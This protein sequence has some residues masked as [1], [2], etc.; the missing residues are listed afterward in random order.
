MHEAVTVTIHDGDCVHP[1]CLRLC[2]VYVQ[3]LGWMSM[4]PCANVGSTQVE[5]ILSVC[6]EVNRVW[7]VF[8]GVPPQR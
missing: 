2:M 4:C 5:H 3:G 7:A 6:G 1:V 8:I